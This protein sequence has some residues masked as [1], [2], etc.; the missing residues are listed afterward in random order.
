[1]D[2]DDWAS[3]GA[4]GDGLGDIS[5]IPEVKLPDPPEPP[6]P[7]SPKPVP[8]PPTAWTNTSKSDDVRASLA[9]ARPYPSTP[10]GL[11]RDNSET[12]Q[13]PGSSAPASS[14]AQAGALDRPRTPSNSR[15]GVALFVSNLPYETS[16]DQIVQFF[17]QSGM[18]AVSVRAIRAQEKLRGAVVTLGTDISPERALSLNGSL[19][20]GRHINVRMDSGRDNRRRQNNNNQ[21][22]GSSDRPSTLPSQS[23][24]GRRDDSSRYS[25]QAGRGLGPN[26]RNGRPYSADRGSV[27]PSPQGQLASDP[28]PPADSPFS[29]AST[30]QD[31]RDRGDNFRQGRQ[32]SRKQNL[33]EDPTIPVGPIPTGRKK[34]ELKPRTKPLPVLEVDQ[35]LIDGPVTS[36][37]VQPPVHRQS[38]AAENSVSNPPSMPPPTVDEAAA[39]DAESKLSAEQSLPDRLPSEERSASEDFP[40]RPPASE[41]YASARPIADKHQSTRERSSSGHEGYIAARGNS[42]NGRRSYQTTDNRSQRRSRQGRRGG[43]EQG[44]WKNAREGMGPKATVTKGTEKNVEEKKQFKS[45]NRFAA[46]GDDADEDN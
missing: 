43:E 34:L 33:P 9:R 29:Q 40:S 20:G 24:F 39:N 25:R 31:R 37:V 42:K 27:Q 35:R 22:R 18:P 30:V 2:E 45:V 12:Q 11:R 21:D 15:G 36:P 38:S 28:L 5:A 8:P 14:G 32:F 44:V 1:M 46:L 41:R 17:E 10:P 6:K 7:E 26:L 23:G 16:Q 4:D 3:D 19:F 13:F